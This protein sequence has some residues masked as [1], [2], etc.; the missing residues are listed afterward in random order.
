MASDLSWRTEDIIRA[1]SLRWLIEVFFENW[2]GYE[3]WDALTKQPGNE[4]S[5]H[6]LILSLLV[7]HCLLTQ[8][9][10]LANLKHKQPAY[11]VG[12]V[13]NRVRLEGILTVC[14]DLATS[15]DPKQQLEQITVAFQE[16]FQLNPSDKHM[17]GRDL[18]RLEPTPALKYRAMECLS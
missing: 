1:Y 18:G 15:Q 2:K 10:Q 12:S 3:G 6:G 8:P 4:G 13:I 7:D 5:E 17:V 9:D 11:T 16:L 14:Q